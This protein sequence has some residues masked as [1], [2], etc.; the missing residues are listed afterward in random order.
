LKRPLIEQLDGHMMRY[1]QLI[2]IYSDEKSRKR[3]ENVANT[4]A[5]SFR[6]AIFVSIASLRDF[7]EKIMRENIFTLAP[8]SIIFV[9]LGNT[10]NLD[11]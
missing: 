5:R 9:P 8:P 2:M 4:L 3:V 10:A 1:P 6:G 7:K 11:V